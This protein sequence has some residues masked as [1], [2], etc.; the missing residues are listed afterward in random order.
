MN[1]HQGFTLIELMIV[2]AIIGILAAI[3][4]P[5]YN[6][7]VLRGKISEAHGELSTARTRMEQYFADNR[8][9]VGGPCTGAAP[10]YFTYACSPAATAS[11]FT[12]VATGLANEGLSGVSFTINQNDDRRTVIDSTTHNCWLSSKKGSC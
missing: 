11:A 9:Y 2:V 10:K 5:Q 6:D 12:I 1:K 8:T 7:Y 4:V 3:A